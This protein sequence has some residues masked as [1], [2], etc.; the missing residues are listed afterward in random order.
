MHISVTKSGQAG[1]PGTRDRRHISRSTEQV[2][3]EANVGLPRVQ[4]S[5]SH[6]SRS[7]RQTANINK[8]AEEYFNIPLINNS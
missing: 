7:N 1:R 2:C 8:S 5:H 3:T 6:V 4:S